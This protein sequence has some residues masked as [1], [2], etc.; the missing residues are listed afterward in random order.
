MLYV[1]VHIFQRVAQISHPVKVKLAGTQRLITYSDRVL[2]K[3]RQVVIAERK[4]R[5]RIAELKY[6][7]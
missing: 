7:A 3:I 1:D 5:K 4:Q 2:S 6:L